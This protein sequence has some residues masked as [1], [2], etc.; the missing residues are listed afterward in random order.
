MI[1]NR[2]VVLVVHSGCQDL[3]FLKEL[4]I[5]L[6][7]I[8][9]LDTQNA[10]QR[11]LQLYRQYSLEELLVALNCPFKFYLQQET[12]QTLLYELF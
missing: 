5:D 7:P 11:P 4:N 10:A 1:Y 3:W 2:D 9:I 6:Q 8:D 12:L